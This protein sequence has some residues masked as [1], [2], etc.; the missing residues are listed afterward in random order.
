MV[1]TVMVAVC[2]FLFLIPGAEGADPKPSASFEL[3]IPGLL[4][5]KFHS[6]DGLGS[7]SE[8]LEF[9]DGTSGEIRKLPGRVRYGDITLKR[10][11]T[12]DGSVAAWRALVESGTGVVER[13]NGT[14]VVFDRSGKP[15]ARYHFYQGWPAKVVVGLD[16]ETGVAIETLVIAVE[17]ISRE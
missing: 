1:R 5:A 17:G 3:S 12:S 2:A 10:G 9:R 13:K 11:V 7:E 14:I 16:A 6:V 8:I 15:V 4:A